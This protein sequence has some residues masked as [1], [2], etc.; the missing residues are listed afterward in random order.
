MKRFLTSIVII[1]IG[2]FAGAQD[3]PDAN[4]GK[5][6]I[7]VYCG[8]ALPKTFSYQVSRKETTR[9][10][11]QVLKTLSFPENKLTWKGRVMQAFGT[12]TQMDLPD[13]AML[14][15]LWEKLRTSNVNDSLY[16]WNSYPFMRAATG[17][18]WWDRS[19]EPNKQYSYKI[20]KIQDGKNALVGTS[21]AVSIPGPVRDFT[22]RP[23]SIAG[24]GTSVILTYELVRYDGMAGARV[25]RGNYLRDNFELIHPTLMYTVNEGKKMMSLIDASVLDKAQY[26]YYLIPFDYYGNEGTPTDTLNVYNS[27][28][29]NIPSIVTNLKAESH[30][31][32]HMVQ[33][34]WELSTQEELVSIDIYK[35]MAYDGYYTKIG[36]VTPDVST[37][38]DQNVNP[39]TTYYYTIVL[40]AP[41]GK[42][43]PSA[44]I[45]VIYKGIEPN[46]FPP[47]NLKAVKEGNTVRLSWEKAGKDI[48]AYYVYR[49]DGYTNPMKPI[50]EVIISSDSIIGFTDS[51]KNMNGS[52]VLIYAVASE[53]TSYNISPLSDRVS[54]TATVEMPIPLHLNA[55]VNNNAI[56]L[57]WDD[58]N[59]EYPLVAGYWIYRRNSNKENNSNQKI[60]LNDM[61]TPYGVNSYIDSTAMEGQHYFYSIV[62]VGIDTTNVSSFSQEIGAKVQ[63][64]IP[65]SPG[66]VRVLNTQGGVLLQWTNPLDDNIKTIQIYK[67]K[68]GGNLELVKS[69]NSDSTEW[70]DKDTANDTVYFY[71]IVNVDEKGHRSNSQ[72]PIGI[73]TN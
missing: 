67:A 28:M 17:T 56:H 64:Q 72:D 32:D 1:F 4:A 8:N 43:Y 22:I 5:E 48:R 57:F 18:G 40:N 2:L 20:E 49:T 23:G 65:L 3:K 55:M 19:V 62:S 33:L 47:S 12:N 69:L 44:R 53:N 42:T 41:Y 45:P 27:G 38:S 37:F 25:Y 60:R 24:N 52:S 14:E 35:A 54:I 58:L 39:V 61:P 16:F 50:S 66:Q 34:K 71:Q 51:L 9:D 26:S 36:S 15:T 13:S 68:N 11:W 7:F 30:E 10:D 29:K 21:K 31:K 70:I 59:S 6:G 73:H 63:E 46:I